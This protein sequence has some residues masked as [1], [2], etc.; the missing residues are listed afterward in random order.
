MKTITKQAIATLAFLSV[1]VFAAPIQTVAAQP[2]ISMVDVHTFDPDTFR[3]PGGPAQSYYPGIATVAKGGT[4]SFHDKGF[5]EHTVTSYTVKIVVD[6]EGVMVSLPIPDGKF[7]SG[8]ATPIEHD[9]TW[10]LD[11]SSL[12]T[13]DYNYFCLIHPWMQATLRIVQ[14]NAPTSIGVN[15]DHA[16]GQTSQFFAGSGSWGF[17]PRSLRVSQ[18]TMVTVVD[19]GILPHT[20]T[21]YTNKIQ[22]VEGGHK[23]NIPIPDGTFN[24]GPLGPT[25]SYTLNTSALNKGTYAYFCQFHPW[26]LGSLTVA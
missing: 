25:Q 12:A 8:I 5:E 20:L 4:V 21:S 2:S 22:I 1:L 10:T 14:R 24:S 15:I 3:F 26:M 18:G 11:T 19:K 13:G 16:I 17:T 7:D 23:L 9:D 6:F